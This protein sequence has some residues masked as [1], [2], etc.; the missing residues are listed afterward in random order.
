MSKLKPTINQYN[1]YVKLVH[2]LNSP[3]NKGK[4]N[5]ESSNYLAFIDAL[6][7]SHKDLMRCVALCVNTGF[8]DTNYPY[9]IYRNAKDSGTGYEMLYLTTD[10]SDIVTGKQIGRAHV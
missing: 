8:V 4:I 6:Q 2:L 7:I 10:G 1:A 9:I 3:L 5:C